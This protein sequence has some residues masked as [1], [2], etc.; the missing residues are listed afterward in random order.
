MKATAPVP[1]Y[2]DHPVMNMKAPAGKDLNGKPFVLLGAG[3]SLKGLQTQ[4]AETLGLSCWGCEI[5]AG[6]FLKGW[7]PQASPL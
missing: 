7:G 1:G 2:S 6:G 5:S 3:L 4:D